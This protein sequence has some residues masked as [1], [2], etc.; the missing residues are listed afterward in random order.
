[1]PTISA[2]V[3]MQ[4]ELAGAGGGWTDITADTRIGVQPLAID[5]G[6]LGSGPLD[7]VA[8]TGTMTWAMD[9]STSNSGGVA[10]YYSPGHTNARAGWDIGIGVRCKLTYGGTDYYKGVGT[11]IGV[12][13]DAGQYQRQAVTCTAVDWMDEAAMTRIRGIGIQTNQRSDQIIDTIVTNSVTRQ[14]AATSYDTGQSTFA[15]SLDNMNDTQTPVL[16]ALADTTISELGYLYVKGGTTGGVLKFEDRHARPKFGAAVGSFDETMV[17]LDVARSRA[18]IINRVYVVVH[19]RTTAG[20]AS[21]LYELTTTDSVPEVAAG[22]TIQITAPFREAS[23]KSYRV[24]GTSVITPVSGTDWIANTASDGSGSVITSDV[25]VT[26]AT[27]AA[28]AVTF[29][30]VNN[31]A[32]TAY[33]T[34]LQVRGTEVADVSHTVMSTA[35]STSATTYG[36]RDSRIDMKYESNAGEFAFNIAEW[37]LAVYKDPRYVI[38]Q[39]SIVGNSSAYLMAQALAREPGDKIT[40]AE[41]MTGIVETGGSGAEIGYFINGCRFS[42]SGGGIIRVSWILSPAEQQNFWIL[43]QVGASELG[44]STVLGFA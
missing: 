37:I 16:A 39:M 23:I 9:N 15:I 27:T 4:C 29:N 18:D 33:L 7:R 22:F 34:T 20:S 44:I 28:N 5:Y 17:S 41:T 42:V 13:P 19:P 10:G 14:P 35:D 30:I 21:V 24:A 3:V 25:A 11:L 31:G 36:E 2:T 32:V 8:S 1:M 26:L 38:Q 6:I 43:Q 40:L 12:I